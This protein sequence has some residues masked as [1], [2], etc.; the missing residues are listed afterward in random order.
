MP[1]GIVLVTTYMDNLGLNKQERL[2]AL[3]PTP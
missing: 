2:P 3:L 1:T